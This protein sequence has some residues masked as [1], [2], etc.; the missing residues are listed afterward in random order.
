MPILNFCSFWTVI[1][2]FFLEKQT[3]IKI[4]YLPRNRGNR[5]CFSVIL[6]FWTKFIKCMC[7]CIYL[8]QLTKLSLS[9][10]FISSKKVKGHFC[11]KP[12][13]LTWAVG[14]NGCFADKVCCFIFSNSQPFDLLSYLSFKLFNSSFMWSNKGRVHEF[15]LYFWTLEL[16]TFL[17]T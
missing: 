3:K 9:Y 7:C 10:V 11:L 8:S 2:L 13:S 5:F 16:S 17:N 1:G 12:F 15:E 4:V 6:T 14:W